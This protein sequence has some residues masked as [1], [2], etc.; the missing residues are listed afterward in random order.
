MFSYSLLFQLCE[1]GIILK[2]SPRKISCFKSSYFD[3]LGR[4]S[5]RSVWRTV[6]FDI[7]VQPCIILMRYEM[8]LNCI[9]SAVA[10][11]RASDFSKSS[12]STSIMKLKMSKLS[13]C[14]ISHVS[15]CKMCW[16]HGNV[17][18]NTSKTVSL[19]RKCKL[20]SHSC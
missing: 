16:Q 18:L 17:N 14:C 20:T 10:E 7:Y 9:K 12:S 2:H 5:N 11:A 8:Y 1:H 4:K 13:N 19:S 3:Q 15:V 6:E